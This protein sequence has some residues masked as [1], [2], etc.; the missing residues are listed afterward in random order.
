MP[1]SKIF[2]NIKTYVNNKKDLD[3]LL[4][5]QGIITLRGYLRSGVY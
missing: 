5:K 3:E 4:E 2:N 1:F